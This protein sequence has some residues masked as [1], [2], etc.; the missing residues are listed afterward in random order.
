LPLKVE[1]VF[2]RHGITLS[3]FHSRTSQPE[4]GLPPGTVQT[5]FE[6]IDLDE[7][8]LQAGAQ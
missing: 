5:I 8:R 2:L 1:S 6:F 4:I 3:D 7:G